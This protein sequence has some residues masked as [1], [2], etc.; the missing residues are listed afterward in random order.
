MIMTIPCMS[1]QCVYVVWNTYIKRVQLLHSNCMKPT[2]SESYWKIHLSMNLIEMS[3]FNYVQWQQPYFNW[4]ACLQLRSIRLL[5][6]NW[7][8]SLQLCSI[9]IT[10][11]WLE[12]RSL[13]MF[14]RVSQQAQ[15]FLM[16]L[17]VSLH[18]KQSRGRHLPDV[19]FNT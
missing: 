11:F 5:F 3:V 13:I 15:F 8:V 1:I 19:L 9:T 14:K 16:H 10:L 4:N 17:R 6:S 12:C 18:G 7:N 2:S